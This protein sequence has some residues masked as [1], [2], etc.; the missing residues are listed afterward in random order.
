MND[1]SGSNNKQEELTKEN[2]K[3]KNYH[4][5]LLKI[6]GTLN[7]ITKGGGGTKNVLE[8]IATTSGS[9]Y[10]AKRWLIRANTK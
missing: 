5:P 8:S 10:L 6:Y 7:R 4:S 9:L 3:R 1:K 2:P